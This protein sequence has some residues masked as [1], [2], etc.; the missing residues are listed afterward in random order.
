MEKTKV[1]VAVSSEELKKLS[2]GDTQDSECIVTSTDDLQTDTGEDSKA[3]SDSQRVKEKIEDLIED[4][5]D[6]QHEEEKNT[7]KI[8]STS[9]SQESE[10]K[11]IKVQN[12]RES[13]SEDEK[14]LKRRKIIKNEGAHNTSTST[15]SDNYIA[16]AGW[17]RTVTQ[18]KSGASAGKYDVYFF[19]P[20]GKKLRSRVEVQGYL[21]QNNIKNLKVT[22][23]EFSSPL[24]H[25][26]DLHTQ[27][28]LPTR[29]EVRKAVT[30]KNKI[31][32]KKCIMPK[33]RVIQRKALTNVKRVKKQDTPK[34]YVTFSDSKKSKVYAQ[35]SPFT[36]SFRKS[37]SG[38]K[39]STRSTPI[40]SST[41]GR[42]IFPKSPS[43][44]IEE[45]KRNA[46]RRIEKSPEVERIAPM[47]K[48]KKVKPIEKKKLPLIKKM[49]NRTTKSATQ[50]KR[51]HRRISQLPLRYREENEEEGAAKKEPI[52]KKALRSTS[53][54]RE[55]KEK[56]TVEKEDEEFNPIL[57]ECKPTSSGRQT[58]LPARFTLEDVEPSP[59]PR[60]P[61]KNA[62]K[63]STK[64]KMKGRV[65]RK[66]IMTRGKKDAIAKRNI[67][68]EKKALEHDVLLLKSAV[69]S[70]PQ[71]SDTEE[72]AFLTLK[73][74][75]VETP[76]TESPIRL[77]MSG[78]GEDDSIVIDKVED[79]SPALFTP[80]YLRKKGP[81]KALEALKK[82]PAGYTEAISRTVSK[83]K[84]FEIKESKKLPKTPKSDVRKKIRPLSSPVDYPGLQVGTTMTSSGRIVKA[85]NRISPSP[86]PE[87]KV[88]EDNIHLAQKR[89]IPLP[90]QKKQKKQTFR[91]KVPKVS[92]KMYNEEASSDLDEKKAR[93]SRNPYL[94]YI[95]SSD[96]ARTPSPEDFLF[97]TLQN[98]DM[99]RPE[100]EVRRKPAPV[101]KVPSNRKADKGMPRFSK[102]SFPSNEFD[103]DDLFDP[104]KENRFRKM[105]HEL[106]DSIDGLDMIELQLQVTGSRH[107]DLTPK[108][109]QIFFK[110]LKAQYRWN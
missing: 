23:F 67:E 108:I 110:R 26:N 37:F 63:A 99:R 34:K 93:S 30:S 5:P 70:T 43:S 96:H 78:G 32:K 75:N 14:V 39:T 8:N 36:S 80:R 19:S 15:N 73:R 102:S 105:Q 2:L 44:P 91:A 16:P 64:K 1:E 22:D 40:L 12:K 41:R 45:P 42:K 71:V 88:K 18:R 86:P 46:R 87:K 20:D 100:L 4:I 104:H 84:K 90:K 57:K 68:K 94:D 56:Q 48:E 77:P 59:A 82:V 24:I 66:M 92:K 29:S 10:S 3:V 58:R 103:P 9:Q 52:K 53:K 51:K 31:T 98:E 62:P 35:S 101:I 25:S 49:E 6:S 55:K 61:V 17:S 38:R 54:E 28:K 11:L 83:K 107:D 76:V 85:P 27:A 47:K 74:S 33:N 21:E 72:D 65:S 106:D 81:N 89:D 79:T 95:M 50:V 60:K 97:D 109:Q 7:D 13:D 69:S